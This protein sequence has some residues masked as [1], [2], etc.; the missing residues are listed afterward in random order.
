MKIIEEILSV[1][2]PYLP[3]WLKGRVLGPLVLYSVVY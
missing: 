3:V 2:V 1:S